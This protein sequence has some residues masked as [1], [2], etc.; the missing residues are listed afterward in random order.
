M[1]YMINLC[2]KA[3]DVLLPHSSYLSFI[4]YDSKCH[5][6]RVHP[7]TVIEQCKLKVTFDWNFVVALQYVLQNV[8]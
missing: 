3:Y 8:I 2:I 7:P 1:S 4:Y 5:S 6:P